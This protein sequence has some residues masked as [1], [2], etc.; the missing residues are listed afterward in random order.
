MFVVIMD[1]RQF[2]AK[3]GVLRD[4]REPKITTKTVVL[5]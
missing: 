2:S 1:I 5:L 4:S 3:R